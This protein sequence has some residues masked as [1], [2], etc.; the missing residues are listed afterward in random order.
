MEHMTMAYL[1]GVIV[2]K[3]GIGFNKY[4]QVIMEKKNLAKLNNSPQYT[5]LWNFERF[6]KWFEYKISD[7]AASLL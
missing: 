1:D 5:K 4:K 3:Q 2:S 7:V 6:S